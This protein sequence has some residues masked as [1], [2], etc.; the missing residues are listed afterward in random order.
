MALTTQEPVIIILDDG[1]VSTA[2]TLTNEWMIRKCTPLFRRMLA[3]IRTVFRDADMS[4]HDLDELILVGGSSHMPVVRKFIADSLGHEPVKNS[5]PDT[6][7][8]LGVGICAGMKSRAADVGDLVLTDVCPF[9]LGIASFNRSDPTR[10]QRCCLNS[11]SPSCTYK[12]RR[13]QGFP[14]CRLFSSSSQL[15][16][17]QI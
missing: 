7:I 8:A 15:P 4:I 13:Y 10:N 17:I 14:W 1:V 9:T 11:V 12:N 6:A 16:A 2:Q 3:P 5:R